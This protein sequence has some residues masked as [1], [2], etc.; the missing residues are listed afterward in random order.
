MSNYC[1]YDLY[2][3]TV[4]PAGSGFNSTNQE[5]L[6]IP[7]NSL[8][9]HGTNTEA[10]HGGI[11][12]KIRDLPRYQVAPAGIIQVEYNL[13]PSKND[14][15]YDLS[16]ID[17]SLTR[18]FEGD[19]GRGGGFLEKCFL[20]GS[21][22]LEESFVGEE[23]RWRQGIAPSGEQGVEAPDWRDQLAAASFAE[24][25]F[26]ESGEVEDD[27]SPVAA[28]PSVAPEPTAAATTQAAATMAP[29]APRQPPGPIIPVRWGRNQASSR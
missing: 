5:A 21:V 29:L 10:I 7:A 20:S 13:V 12:L 19:F 8:T 22:L 28:S 24:D 3:W 4:G 16:A 1:P 14:I 17:V 18:I 26:E 25:E 27:T 9:V 15:W 23:F 2:F 11:S 6:T